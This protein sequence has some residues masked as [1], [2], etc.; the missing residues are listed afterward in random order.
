VS[1]LFQ[2]VEKGVFDK[3]GFESIERYLRKDTTLDLNDRSI[4][5]FDA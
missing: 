3:S 2:K 1:I 4:I 5:N